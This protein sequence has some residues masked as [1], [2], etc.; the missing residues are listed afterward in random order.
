MDYFAGFY[1]ELMEAK[2]PRSQRKKSKKSKGTL[3]AYDM[4]ETLFKDEKS[5]VRVRDKDNNVVRSLDNKQYNSD[6]LGD[7]ETYEYDDF[8][9]ARN[10]QQNVEP[11][12]R[13]IKDMKRNLKRNKPVEIVTARADFDEKDVLKQTLGKYGINIDPKAKK[14]VH[15]RRAGNIQDGSPIGDRK[16]K[17][18]QDSADKLGVKRARMYDDS[19]HVLKDMKGNMAQNRPD[20]NFKSRFV[21]PDKK[22]QVRHRTFREFVEL[23]E[24]N[25]VVDGVLNAALAGS[26][27]LGAVQSPQDFV[28]MGS[29]GIGPGSAYNTDQR[30][31]KKPKFTLDHGAVKSRG[32]KK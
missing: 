18:V 28:K 11:N 17:I 31:K 21:S 22:G 30:K 14:G 8:R 23:D 9:K 2:L 12:K 27:A 32:S 26:F 5:R 16:A 10:H 6:K 25:K 15:L 29:G 4:D 7:N 24:R 19:T 13:M 1:D 3:H 20:I